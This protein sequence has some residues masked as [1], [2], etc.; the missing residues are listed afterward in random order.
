[1][2]RWPFAII[3]LFSFTPMPITV[4]RILAPASGYPIGRYLVAQLVGRFPRFLILA[5]IGRVLMIP[6]WGVVAML[7]ILVLA[8][9]VSSR[10]PSLAPELAPGADPEAA[11]APDNDA[12]PAP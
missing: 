3:V 12:A 5:W 8:V 11:P 1:M 10:G 7:A 2:E 9:Y 4:I 6:T